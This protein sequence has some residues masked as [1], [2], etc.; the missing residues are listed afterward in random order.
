MR[1]TESSNCCAS[2]VARP[3]ATTIAMIAIKSGM[4]PATTA[5]KTRSRMMSAAGSPNLSSPFSRSSCERRLKSW[6][7]VSVPVT[8]TANGPSSATASTFST[9]VSVSPSSERAIGMIVA[10]RSSETSASPPSRYVRARPRAVISLGDEIPNVGLEPGRVDRVVLGADD[11]DV[12]HRGRR[13]PGKAAS[14]ASSAR[15]DSG[16]FVGAPS[17]VRLPP[18]NTTITAIARTAAIAHAPS[19][20]QGWR[21]LAAARGPVL[22]RRDLQTRSPTRT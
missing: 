19:T 16:L 1:N 2:S 21:A 10:C 8:D 3:S 20:R 18:R 13:I 14:R 7:S 4:S 22:I 12:G 6:S 15:S 11:D 5:P 9:S 17:V